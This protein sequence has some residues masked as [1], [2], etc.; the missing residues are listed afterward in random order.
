MRV[1]VSVNVWNGYWVS[2]GGVINYVNVWM[3]INMI[4]Y[5]CV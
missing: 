3:C 4:M 2:R 1:E 5:A